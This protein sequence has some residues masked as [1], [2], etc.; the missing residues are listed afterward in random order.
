MESPA[1]ARK[2]MSADSH[3]AI[4]FD[5]CGCGLGPA[6][7]A[8][9]AGTA[10]ARRAVELVDV[11][12]ALQGLLESWL[13]DEGIDVVAPGAAASAAEPGA[14]ASAANP[15]AA[16][17]DLVIVD[18]PF[19]R[20]GGVDLIRRIAN[21]HPAVPVL[22]LS[23]TFFSGVECCGPVA[24]T[25]GVACVLPKPVTREALAAAVRRV[26]PP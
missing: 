23:S 13:H 16:A 11:D 9:P 4:P 12:A 18:V 15:A 25:L 3:P 2:P 24:R 14:A 5:P 20:Q 7:T 26:L 17:I 19:P 10:A 22:A 21:R 6:S 1:T 8:R